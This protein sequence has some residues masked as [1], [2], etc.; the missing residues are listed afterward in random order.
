MDDVRKSGLLFT[1]IT[2]CYNSE[3]TISRTIE[4]VLNQTYAK[5][6]YL[7]I[8]GASADKTVQAAERYRSQF[9]KKGI[10]YRVISEPDNGIYDAMNKGIRHACGTLIGFLNAGDWYERDAVYTA[11]KEYLYVPYDYF[12]ADVRLMRGN[13]C[14]SVKHSKP[15][16]FPSSRHWNHP[17]SFCS[18]QVYQELGGFQCKGIHDD[19][20][21]FLRVRKSKKRLRIVNKVLANFQTGGVSNKK[22]LNM[23]RKRIADRYKGYR[24][25]GYS[26]LCM[27]ECIGMEA[28]KYIIS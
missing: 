25:N 17:A 27:M 1:I 20:E 12:Y 3:K 2:V 24:K 22:N 26:P 21:F 11:A 15:D 14:V 16:R 13:G 9:Q 6:E 10:A 8:D 28:A 23:C 19:F 18:K 7:I 4:S 5:L